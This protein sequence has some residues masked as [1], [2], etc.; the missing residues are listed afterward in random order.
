MVQKKR[1][2]SMRLADAE[3]GFLSNADVTIKEA[4]FGTWQEAGEKALVNG[5]EADDPQ[6]TIVFEGE[7][8]QEFRPERFGAGKA[9]RLVPSEDGE[10]PAEEGQGPFLI[11]AE[12]SK[13]A[14]LHKQSTAYQ[15]L[16]S[17]VKP[18]KG[19]LK[20]SDDAWGDKGTE[21]LVG[22]R[23][24]VVRVPDPRQA[25]GT[26]LAEGEKERTILVCDEIYELG[27]SGKAGKSAKPKKARADDDDEDENPKRKKK[28]A[29]DDDD[30][31]AGDEDEA[32]GGDEDASTEAEKVVVKMLEKAGGSL[33][34]SALAK[35]SFSL[36]AKS[37]NKGEIL[38]L[39]QDEDWIGDDDR[40][41]NVNAKKQTIESVEE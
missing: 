28:P 34:I 8:G 12:D 14:G 3:D 20:L 36:I 19:K 2:F 23:I 31:D 32:E 10:E 33:A 29:E 17:L 13:A 27:G 39:F 4:H 37:A 26:A 35:K 5:R 16:A 21:A 22:M 6:L 15:F 40:P 1:K 25:R 30:D 18:A 9:A 41:W 7:D 38:E 24:H 11:P